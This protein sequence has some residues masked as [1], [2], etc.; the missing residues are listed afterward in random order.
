ML[1]ILA[2]VCAAL[3]WAN[4]DR[5]FVAVFATEAAWALFEAVYLSMP[6]E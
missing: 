2:C 1:C 6:V 5:L 4:E 3:A